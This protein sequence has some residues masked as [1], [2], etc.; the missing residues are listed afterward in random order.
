MIQRK[1]MDKKRFSYSAIRWLL[2][3]AMFAKS[4]SIFAQAPTI[5][6][7]VKDVSLHTILL[8][9]KKQSGRNIVYNNNAIEK[10]SHESVELKNVTVEEALKK[11]LDGKELKFKI[12]DGVIIVEPSNDKQTPAK[13]AV[14]YQTLKGTVYDARL[15]TPLIG[16][17]VAVV[18]LEMPIGAATD[19]DGNF[20]IANVPVGRQTVVVSYVGYKKQ[21]ID[22][23]MVLSAKENVLNIGLEESVEKLEEVKVT[24]NKTGAINDMATVSARAFTIEETERFAGSLG[25]PSRMATNYAGVFTAGDQRNDIVIRGNSPTGLLWQVE[26]VPIPS[27]NHFS[28]FGTTGGP[29]SM[30][31][32]NVLSRSDF[33]TSAFPSE[34]G[35]ASSGVFDLKMR[36]GN[37]EKHEFLFQMGMN[38]FEGGAEGPISAEKKSSYI[39][40][41]R[42]SML[43]LVHD[44]LWIDGLPQYEDVNFKVNFPLKSG[45]ISFF[46]IGGISTISFKEEDNPRAGTTD[47]YEMQTKD[48]STTG[49]T[50]VNYMHNFSSSS[51]LKVAVAASTRRNYED[52]DSIV[53]DKS[54]MNLDDNKYQ[55]DEFIIT[56]KL[57][58]KINARNTISIG[59]IM[60][61]MS[62][63]A[64]RMSS[65]YNTPLNILTIDEPYKSSGKD[66]LLSQGYMQWKHN[67]T[68]NLYVQA[69]ANG[70]YFQFNQ[71][72]AI[73]PRFG[74]SWQ[75]AEK[76]SIGFGYGLH[77]QI[78][79]LN[80][81]FIQSKIGKDVNGR[82]LYADLQ[83][84]RNL[85]FTRSHQLAV[86]HNYSFNPNLRLKT[87]TYYQYLY[88]VPVKPSKGYFSMINVGAAMS[89][90]EEDSLLNEGY[91]KNYGVEF[92]LEKF[93]SQHYYFLITTSLFN[94]QY[95]GY[96]KVWRNTTY[97]GNYIFNILG[98]YEFELKENV[99]L[100]LNLRT[101]Y[102]GG[103]R[104]TPY[105][106]QKSIEEN[107]THYIYDQAF[108]KQ[109]KAYFRMDLRIGV[110]FQRKR[111]TH[112]LALD[113]SNITN[114]KNVYREKYNEVTGQPKTTYQQGIYPMG[115]YRLNF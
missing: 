36:N 89:V 42:Y 41:A 22:N 62:F 86:S 69:G 66:M 106:L 81:Y 33:F 108:E 93:F 1:R 26:D 112:E 107:D 110:I 16:A 21:Q 2:V 83:T 105:D 53:N 3:F 37:N 95:R 19:I 30:L 43:G 6:I 58:H 77:S 11:V 90:P 96:D 111:F 55:Q 15:N 40:N 65:D 76:Q 5:S 67:F 68:D 48:G 35:N 71:K 73:D 114:Y 14:F 38:G 9:I 51:M 85:D 32:N 56:S 82:Q 78:Q 109:V 70:L 24:F 92:T 64:D 17:T 12:I 59:L 103:R 34:Y 45:K 28:V 50:G 97:N 104:I 63:D 29:I 13:P 87:E 49:V 4:M 98:G 74:L 10:Y 100:N 60:Q 72:F 8:E 39:V 18:G 27:P 52:I 46:G 54:Y 88:Q 47:E 91:G 31:N 79:P 20:K 7:S 23:I 80:V 57:T 102:A 99:L 94:S 44:L 113:V 25:D 115:L 75:F 84:N 101:I 61:D